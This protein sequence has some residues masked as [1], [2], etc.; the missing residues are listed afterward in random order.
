MT[1]YDICHMAKN[2]MKYVNMGIKRT[3][4]IRQI[5]LRT[6][7]SLTRKKIWKKKLMATLLPQSLVLS[8]QYLTNIS[9][10]TNAL[11]RYFWTTQNLDCYR[12]CCSYRLRFSKIVSTFTHFIWK[13][14]F[15]DT[16]DG[17]QPKQTTRS[18]DLQRWLTS[19]FLDL[20]HS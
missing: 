14:L 16:P 19:L 5:E 6:L 12:F 8:I 18:C 17:W 3:V 10:D 1:F 13:S 15:A 7:K 20:L 4:S 11:K 2:V 9:S